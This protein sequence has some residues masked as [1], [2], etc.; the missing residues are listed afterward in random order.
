[1]LVGKCFSMKSFFAAV[2]CDI[3]VHKL[4]MFS[5]LPVQAGPIMPP[6]GVPV[7]YLE[8]FENLNNNAA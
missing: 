4:V 1:M 5:E 3:R 8:L 6:G 2:N 7:R